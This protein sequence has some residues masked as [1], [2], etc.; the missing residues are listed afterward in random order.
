[1]VN[2]FHLGAKD[3]QA[4]SG[5]DCADSASESFLPSFGA[6]LEFERQQQSYATDARSNMSRQVIATLVLDQS[7]GLVSDGHSRSSIIRDFSEREP[8]PVL[9]RREKVSCV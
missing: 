5:V 7:Y 4:S 2:N 3:C 6:E 1:M 9:E 8:M